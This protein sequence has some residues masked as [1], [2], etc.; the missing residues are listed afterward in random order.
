[1][2]ISFIIQVLKTVTQTAIKL[3]MSLQQSPHDVEKLAKFYS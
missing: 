3:V 1:M 2:Q